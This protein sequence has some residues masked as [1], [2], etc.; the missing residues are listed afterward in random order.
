M[1]VHNPE[2]SKSKRIPDF[3]TSPWLVTLHNRKQ[4]H[5]KSHGP[6]PSTR[7][8][9]T[10]IPLVIPGSM[11]RRSHGSCP[12]TWDYL[13][14]LREA[15]YCKYKGTTL[16]NSGRQQTIWG[17]REHGSPIFTAKNATHVITASLVNTRKSKKLPPKFRHQWHRLVRVALKQWIV[18][19]SGRGNFKK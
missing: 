9:K 18:K 3:Q 8:Q 14:I 4:R 17:V 11:R 16:H 7:P 15:L 2:D 6:N 5:L 1:I 13:F 10:K 19:S 12:G